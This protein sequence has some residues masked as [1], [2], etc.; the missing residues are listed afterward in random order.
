MTKPCGRVR[1][2]AYGEA[3]RVRDLVETVGCESP[4]TSKLMY[5]KPGCFSVAMAWG[6]GATLSKKQRAQMCRN[7]LAAWYLAEAVL[8]LRP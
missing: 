3:V 1:R 6:A 5:S 7:C 4:G 8:V 2:L